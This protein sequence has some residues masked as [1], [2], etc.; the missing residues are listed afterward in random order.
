MADY[1]GNEDENSTDWNWTLKRD[2]PDIQKQRHKSLKW[3]ISAH[4]PVS[5]SLCISWQIPSVQQTLETNE[6]VWGQLLVKT[7]TVFSQCF[8]AVQSVV[9]PLRRCTWAQRKLLPQNPQVPTRREKNQA[10]SVRHLTE[11]QCHASLLLST[12]SLEGLVS[13]YILLGE[14]LQTTVITTRSERM[15]CVK[16]QGAKVFSGKCFGNALLILEWTRVICFFCPHLLSCNL[17]KAHRR[18]EQKICPEKQDTVHSAAPKSPLI[19]N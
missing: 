1:L 17:I 6:G 19:F 2:F 5:W 3:L 11:K 7:H 9:L 16:Q 4:G 14:E 10:A 8:V 18:W 15:W 13:G 12:Q